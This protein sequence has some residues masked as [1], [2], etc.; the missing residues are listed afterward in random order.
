MD[1]IVDLFEVEW[2]VVLE[3]RLRYVLLRV[4]SSYIDV[5]F[6]YFCVD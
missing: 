6:E 2:V 4:G 1:W 3:Y 5:M